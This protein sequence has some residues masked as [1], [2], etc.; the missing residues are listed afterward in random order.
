ITVSAAGT[1]TAICTT[2]CGVSGLSNPIVITTGTKPNAPSV[3]SSKTSICGDETATLTASGCGGSVT[4]S[5]G[6]SGSSI[7]VGT[8]G[9]YTAICTNACGVSDASTVITIT[10]GTSPT[11]PI[12]AANK[13]S[14]CD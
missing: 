5:H 7:V 9:T 8:A 14:I 11:A 2:T 3:E 12:I 13:T 1:Y 6:A 4:W 10:G